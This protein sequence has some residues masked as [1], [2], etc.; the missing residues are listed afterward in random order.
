M[1]L[2]DKPYVSDFLKQTILE[3]NLEL[4]STK[5]A[6]SFLQGANFIDEEKAIKAF[7]K[8]NNLRLYSN[9]ENSISWIENN[10]AFTDLP[11]K[12]K[13]FKNKIEFRKLIENLHPNYFYQAIKFQDL[14]NLD[15]SN[16]P[17][18]FII[19]PAVGFFSMG[20]YKVDKKEDWPK[21]V[22][23]IK[24]EINEIKDF[25]PIEVMDATE[26]IA[27]ECIEGDEFAIDCYFD[28][29]GNTVILSLLKHLF[30]SSNDVS[31]RVY[32]TSKELIEEYLESFQQYLN[33][34]GNLANLKNFV[35]HIEIRVDENGKIAPIEVN[36]MRFGGWCT[37]ADL[38]Q[39]AYGF[40]AYKY[41]L[42]NIK[43]D[44]EKLLK[45]KKNITY[46]I[47]VLDNSTDFEAAK[48]NS[49]NYDKLL[50]KFTNVLELRKIDYNKYPLFGFLFCK[51][52]SEDLSELKYILK[53]NLNEFIEL[54]PQQ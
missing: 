51:T 23:D 40:N 13:F 24:A 39:Y 9:S 26:F 33:K 30:S 5:E 52:K 16:F 31:D 3:N 14:Q 37:T 47:M 1:I 36:P 27:E 34:I 42:N 49:F 20:V 43:P 25:Y 29:N 22:E 50:Q 53:S 10:L 32:I 11:K 17:F 44:W 46:S 4:I 7:K 21:I 28:E 2:L 41:F 48:I 8:Q 35:A 45:N 38:A 15:I 12:I 19:K 54:K 18:P 6:K